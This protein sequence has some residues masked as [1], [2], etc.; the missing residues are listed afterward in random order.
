MDLL[1]R[2]GQQIGKRVPPPAFRAE[3][4]TLGQASSAQKRQCNGGLRLTPRPRA[5]RNDGLLGFRYMLRSVSDEVA[6]HWM[7]LF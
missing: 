3:F 1:A 4:Q 2:V 6:L 7:I 5:G